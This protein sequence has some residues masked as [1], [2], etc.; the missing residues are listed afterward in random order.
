MTLSDQKTETSP[1]SGKIKMLI[2]F[3]KKTEVKNV[4]S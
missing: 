4:N 1:H 2:F 3:E